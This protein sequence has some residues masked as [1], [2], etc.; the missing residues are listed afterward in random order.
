M[1]PFDRDDSC[2]TV[3]APGS[4]YGFSA[5]AL[6]KVFVMCHSLSVHVCSDQLDALLGVVDVGKQVKCHDGQVCSLHHHHM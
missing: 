1:L 2:W 4:L 5:F 3:R 6:P